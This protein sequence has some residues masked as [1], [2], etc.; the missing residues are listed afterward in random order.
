M[1]VPPSIL[2]WVWFFMT[3][4]FSVHQLTES[5][6]Q[7]YR[8]N[9][10]QLKVLLF[11]ES[12]M[13]G[14][15]FS[16]SIDKRLQRI[17]STEMLWWYQR[18]ISASLSIKASQRFWIRQP[19]SD[20]ALPN[21]GSYESPWKSVEMVELSKIERQ[22]DLSW[23]NVLNRIGVGNKTSGALLIWSAGLLDHVIVHVRWRRMLKS[24][25]KCLYGVFYSGRRK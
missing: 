23:I 2:Y 10:S 24:I 7:N 8:M 6:C 20:Y 1:E 5:T 17:I 9:L 22:T 14:S 11:D 3:K 16:F 19:F 21:A 13:I 12:S 4:Q 18:C 15:S 25:M